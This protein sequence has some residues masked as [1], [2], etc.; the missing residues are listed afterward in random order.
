MTNFKKRIKDL[1][2]FKVGDRVK[3]RDNLP[4]NWE[5][6][7]QI[8]KII[9]IELASKFYEPP[10]KLGQTVYEIKINSNKL[11]FREVDL[12]FDNQYYNSKKIKQLLKVSNE[13]K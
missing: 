3:I 11:V 8:G 13:T 2:E 4:K 5:G 10:W 12:T 1:P 9:K 6:A 7:G